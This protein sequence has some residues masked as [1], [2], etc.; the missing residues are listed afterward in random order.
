PVAAFPKLRHVWVQIRIVH[1]LMV[2]Q[3]LEPVVM[4][5]AEQRKHAKPIGSQIIPVTVAK[6]NM[7]CAFMRE[8]SELMLSSADQ[9]D[10]DERDRRIPPRRPT[11]GSLQVVKPQRSPNDQRQEDI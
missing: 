9:H 3:M 1:V 2:R 6:Q 8:T 10:R 11:G 7:M 5:R 4:R